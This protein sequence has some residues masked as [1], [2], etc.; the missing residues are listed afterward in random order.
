[1]IFVPRL[2]ST[3]TIFLRIGHSLLL[4][5]L[6]VQPDGEADEF[7]ELL[8]Q[9]LK[10][11]TP[12]ELGLVLFQVEKDLR[13]SLDP[14]VHHSSVSFCTAKESPTE[15]QMYCSSSCSCCRRKPCPNQIGRKE[16][17]PELPKMS[18][19]ALMGTKNALVPDW[20]IV[21][22]LFTCSFFVMPKPEPSIVANVPRLFT[23]SFFTARP[24][25]RPPRP[26]P[27]GNP[28]WGS[29]APPPD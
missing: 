17:N 6:H 26:A 23:S 25:N 19:P 7:R 18:P 15:L 8:H 24:A 22:R 21:P 16:A 29:R 10:R 28:L 13:A 12:Q 5:I 4:Q 20:T 14:P 11:R 9:I 2:T 1:M 27:S 3:C